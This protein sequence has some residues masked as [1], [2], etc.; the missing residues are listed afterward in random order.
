[1]DLYLTS[2]REITPIRVG[3]EGESE[4]HG[5]FTLGGYTKSLSVHFIANNGCC[6]IV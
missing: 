3:G 6:N 5:F 1:M 2:K 4:V